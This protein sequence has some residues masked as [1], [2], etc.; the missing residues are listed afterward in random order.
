[1]E[2]INVYVTAD[3]SPTLFVPELNECYHSVNGALTE[4]EHVFIAAGYRAFEASDKDINI[5]EIGFGTG[6]NAL[7][8][9][10]ES[11]KHSGVVRY[12]GIELHP[13]P[14]NIIHSLNFNDDA[15]VFRQLHQCGWGIYTGITDTFFLRKIN[16]NFTNY[17]LDEKYDVIYLDAFS[18]EVQPELW[19]ED[20]FRKL[21][22]G[23][24]P[25]GIL[26]TYCA[27]GQVRRNMQQAGF[28]VER[29]PGPPGKREMLR[30]R[31]I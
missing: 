4:S 21:F 20:I 16:T 29:L 14:E 15:D 5:L 24:N 13:L 27:K 11:A 9:V 6:L 2:K 3:G 8:T 26:T 23:M 1:M 22:S 25:G 28:T 19:T 30:A 31:R 7:L 12:T 18:P 10:A 17:R